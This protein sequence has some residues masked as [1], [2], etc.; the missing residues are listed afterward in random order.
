MSFYL[1]A[2]TP[3]E[4]MSFKHVFYN[5]DDELSPHELDSGKNKNQKLARNVH[6]F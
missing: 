1:S 6:V 5:D 4:Y 3:R 2:V